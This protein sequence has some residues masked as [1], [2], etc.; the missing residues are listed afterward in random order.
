MFSSEPVELPPGV[1][2]RE[3]HMSLLAVAGAATLCLLAA[4]FVYFTQHQFPLIT[5]GMPIFSFWATGVI[6]YEFTMLGAISATFLFFLWE[7]GLL[8]Q[9]PRKTGPVPDVDS[10][11][12][13]L[14]VRCRPEQAAMAGECLY[15]A[16]AASVKKAEA[17]S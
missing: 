11:R 8:R 15:Q 1:L 7:S 3:S 17:A 14:R 4:L 6:F 5:G 10:G 16:G 9:A 12:I 2:D 13:F